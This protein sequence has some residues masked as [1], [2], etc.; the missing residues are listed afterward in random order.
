MVRTYKTRMATQI[1]E[2]KLEGRRNVEWHILGLLKE[3]QNDLQGA[4]R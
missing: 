3:A 4:V 2:S 1:F